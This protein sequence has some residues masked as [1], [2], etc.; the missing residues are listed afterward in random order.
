MT[1]AGRGRTPSRAR[2]VARS[3]VAVALCSGMNA[4]STAA[5]L[6]PVIIY[7]LT[8]RGGVSRIRMLAWW[9]P[10]A[11][12]VT[13][14]W[15][16]PLLLL[17]R[18]GVSIVPFT[19]SGQVTSTTTSLLN[20]FRGTE[21]WIGYQATNGQP[22]RPLAFDIATG[23][24]Q[25]TILTGL[26]AALGLAGLARSDMPERRFLLWLALGGIA[27]IS[28]GYASSLGSPLEGPLVALI[29]GPASPFRNLWKFDPLVRLP[30][31]FGASPTCWPR[32]GG[33]GT[34]ESAAG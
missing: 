18:Y 3:A 24:L 32:H 6:V 8:R 13:V 29:N 15:F 4:A 25:A 31:A 34:A 16:V 10:A 1:R 5:V 26:L 33:E 30:L 17:S 22:G 27:V 12:L 14:S 11:A 19:E 9:V 23:I 2:A 28:L 20:I 21:S 7:I